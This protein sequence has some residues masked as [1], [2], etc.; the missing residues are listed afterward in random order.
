M[1]FADLFSKKSGGKYE[2]G[3]EPRN[4]KEKGKTQ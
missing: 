1:V 2:N 3:K 4:Q